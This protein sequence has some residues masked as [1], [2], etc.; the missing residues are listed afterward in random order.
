MYEIPEDALPED[1]TA[2]LLWRVVETLDLSRFLSQAKAV[3]GQQGRRVLSVRVLL[4]VWLY[5]ISR[6]I[7]SAREIE[8]SLTSDAAFRWIIGDLSLGRTRLSEF[9]V[10]YG[11]ALDRLFTDVLATLMQRDLVRLDLVAQDGTRVR[12]S[13]SAPSFRRALSLQE[14]REQAALHVKAVFASADDPE[15]SE[16]VKRAREAK[17]LDYQQRVQDAIAQLS[18]I[19]D[20][21]EASRRKHKNE[22]RASTT[23]PQAR[24]MKVGDGGFRPAYNV[25]L[26]TAGS[27]LGGPRTIVGVL[28]THQ[29]SDMNSIGPMLDDIER[30][31]GALPDVLLADAGHNDHNS[32]RL[33]A[34]R[35]VEA[36]VPVSDKGTGNHAENDAPIV[37][38]RDRMQTPE[39]KQLYRAR[40]S[41]C[42][43]PNAHFK[44]RLG[45][46]HLLV[47]GANKVTCAVL[48]TA[49][50]SNLLAH[51]AA[52]LS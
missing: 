2:R 42:E 31:T 15:V 49:L 36:L 26:A 45:L 34:A 44:S 18:T 37:A 9:R 8:R 33:A 28:V 38:W 3:E 1:H 41:L 30:R 13:A 6:G 16:Q 11:E 22:P 52:L 23:D 39:A 27:P 14:C 46:A 17:A 47:R 48:L 25:Q 12:A 32:I 19:Q 29:G 4:T 21:R 40:A 24:V 43:L 50:T 5:A 7:G 20:E 51:A 35:G 10:E